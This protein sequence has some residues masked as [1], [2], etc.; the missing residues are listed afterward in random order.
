MQK[1]NLAIFTVG[2][3]DFG[4]LQNIIK[5]CE[6]DKRF[7]LYLVIGSA[8][9]SKIF[10]NTQKEINSFKLKNKIYFKFNY[11]DS[12]NKDIIKYFNKTLNETNNILLKKKFDASV[13][14]GDRYEMLAI[15][16]ACFYHKIPIMHFCGGSQTLGSLDDRY[17]EYISKMSSVHLL[18]TKHHKKNL[19]NLGIKKN[20]EVVGAPALENIKEELKKSKN[21]KNLDLSFNLDK[22]IVTACFHPETTK[23]KISNLKNLKILLKFLKSLNVNLVFTYPNADAGFQDYIKII[24][25]YLSKK[26]NTYLVKNLGRKKYYQLL[27]ISSVLVGNSSSGIIESSSFKLPTIDIGDRQKGRFRAPNTIHSKFNLKNLRKAY[28][29]ASSKKFI[30]KVN[31]LKNP[32]YKENTSKKSLNIINNFLVR[33]GSI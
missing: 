33:N 30:N 27:K 12:S 5:R 31:R 10:G 3:S 2:R 23:N 26:N 19:F 18:E 4:I 1:H 9:K 22:K 15:S 32:Y 21:S 16:L 17:R 14:L 8:H 11:K 20:L 6:L 24:K 29:K 25:N 7:N 13:I 28:M